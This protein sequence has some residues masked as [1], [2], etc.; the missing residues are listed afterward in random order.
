[1]QLGDLVSH[2]DKYHVRGAS[3][4]AIESINLDDKSEIFGYRVWWESDGDIQIHRAAR[5]Y[6][7]REL[8]IIET[9]N[10]Q[11]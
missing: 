4:G 5:T 3:I 8:K 11:N 6:D 9:E 7:L 10:E 2:S 1:M